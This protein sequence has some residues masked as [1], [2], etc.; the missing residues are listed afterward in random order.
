MESQQIQLFLRIGDLRSQHSKAMVY[1]NP[2]LMQVAQAHCEEMASK[3]FLHYNSEDGK[4]IDQLEIEAGYT[5]T[6]WSIDVMQVK[7]KTSTPPPN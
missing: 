3:E 2:K 6:I 7:K 4:T 1:V 5:P